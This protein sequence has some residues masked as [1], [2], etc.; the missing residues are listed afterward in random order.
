MRVVISPLICEH[1]PR[2]VHGRRVVR[3][4]QDFTVE[5]WCGDVLLF[6]FTVPA[7]FVSDLASIPRFFHRLLPPGE[8][9]EEAAVHDRMYE[10]GVNR[11]FADVFMWLL[12]LLLG[13]PAW[14]RE[15]IFGGLRLFGWRAY[16]E[17]ARK[18][19]GKE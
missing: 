4:T 12:M 1:L 19:E 2:T 18:R 14:K 5:I 15:A 9:D 3:F 10:I 17:H 16:R 7:G 6:T 13:R 8:H 11:F